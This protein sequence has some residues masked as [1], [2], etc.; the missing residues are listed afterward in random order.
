M[1]Q[2]QSCEALVRLQQGHA[3]ARTGSARPQRRAKSPFTAHQD[4][5]EASSGEQVRAHTPA[6][7]PWPLKMLGA[8]SEAPVPAAAPACGL[9]VHRLGSGLLPAR[10]LRSLEGARAGARQGDAGCSQMVVAR[11]HP[12]IIPS[13]VSLTQ[14]SFPSLAINSGFM[15]TRTS[16]SQEPDSLM[17]R[18]RKMQDKNRKAQARSLPPAHGP[19]PVHVQRAATVTSA[20]CCRFSR[21][22]QQLS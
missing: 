8:V 15:L 18:A 12:C 22:D 10:R 9:R 3:P 11:T 19:L 21:A 16:C 13:P 1:E 4:Q 20:W 2:Q 6:R 17:N 7:M 14:L 5:Q